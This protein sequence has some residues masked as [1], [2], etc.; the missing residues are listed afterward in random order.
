MRVTRSFTGAEGKWFY[1]DGGPKPFAK[2]DALALEEAFTL[3]VPRVVPVRKGQNE[4]NLERSVQVNVKTKFE[5]K[6]TRE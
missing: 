6:V 2:E 5:R 3:G 1:D 4:V